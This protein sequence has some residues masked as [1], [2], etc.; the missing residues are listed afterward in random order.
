[1]DFTLD[2]SDF[3]C[4]E[5]AKN[6]IR[7]CVSNFPNKISKTYLFHQQTSEKKRNFKL[8]CKINYK[9]SMRNDLQSVMNGVGLNLNPLTS[10]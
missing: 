8:L 10:Y 4:Y 6:E 9:C 5:V 7:L 1:M 2:R 3:I